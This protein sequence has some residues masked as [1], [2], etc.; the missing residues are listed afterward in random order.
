MTDRRAKRPTSVD[1]EGEFPFGAADYVLHLLAAI[2]QFRDSAL[3]S[4]LKPVGLNVGRYRVL[5][6]LNRFGACTMTEL[7]HFTAIDRTTLT[8]I[9]DQLVA[10]AQVERQTTARDRRQVL[11]A[12]TDEGRKVYIAALGVVFEFNRRILDGIP[13]DAH[14]ATARVLKQMVEN[15]APDALARDSIIHFSR[16]KLPGGHSQSA[17]A[18]SAGPSPSRAKP[19]G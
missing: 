8:R 16:E 5:G 19:S 18:A 7:S 3:D 4:R 13:D 15:L 9:A 6:V 17:K 2:H 14:R 10:N 1:P 11:L 12:L